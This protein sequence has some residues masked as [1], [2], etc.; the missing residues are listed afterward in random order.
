MFPVGGR[1][2]RVFKGLLFQS[3]KEKKNTT[4]DTPT[5][6]TVVS[7][8]DSQCPFFKKLLYVFGKRGYRLQEQFSRQHCEFT[9]ACPG[10]WHNSHN[11]APYDSSDK[12]MFDIKPT[13]GVHR[14]DFVTLVADDASRRRPELCEKYAVV[15]LFTSISESQSTKLSCQNSFMLVSS[16]TSPHSKTGS[17]CP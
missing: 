9:I 3:E 16:L 13:V 10:T 1:F 5:P 12:N 17:F 15:S 4:P 2:C 6:I 14:S 11:E 7:N 8:S